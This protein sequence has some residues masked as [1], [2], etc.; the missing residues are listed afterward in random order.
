M[1]KRMP[2]QINSFNLCGGECDIS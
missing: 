2:C 1:D